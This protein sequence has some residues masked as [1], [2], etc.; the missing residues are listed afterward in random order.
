MNRVI[1]RLR[2]KSGLSYRI[3]PVDSV[4]ER[5][6]LTAFR[7]QA[8]W[9][10]DSECA[11]APPRVSFPISL[12]TDDGRTAVGVV[13]PQLRS[14]DHV[15]PIEGL[16]L[17]AIILPD[18]RRR[19]LGTALL[20]FAITH[21]F[22]TLPWL[23]T[24]VLPLPVSNREWSEAFLARLGVRRCDCVV[25]DGIAIDLFETDRAAWLDTGGSRWAGTVSPPM[26]AKVLATAAPVVY[27]GSTSSNKLAQYAYLFR[28][29][30]L[31]LRRLTH[32]VAL[33]EPQVEGHGDE[34]ETAL[35]AEPLK[36]FSRFAERAQI[37]PFVI[38]D[39]M[40]FIEHFNNDFDDQPM[41]PGPDTKRWWAALGTEGLLKVM[42]ESHLRRAT[43]VCQLGAILGP[44]RYEFFRAEVHGHISREARVS[45]E[46]ERS[47]PY[48]NAAYFH[49]IFIPQGS[50]RTLAEME[51]S[52]FR[53]FDYRRRCLQR[54]FTTLKANARIAHTVQP[55]LPLLK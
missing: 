45:A 18:Y 46:A 55:E 14:V 26:L 12:W 5:E 1:G 3:S 47:F 23:L 11:A 17:E 28:C 44:S 48:S 20:A 43:Y 36:D 37:Y 31:E 21:Y 29:F 38:E 10:S 8:V 7:Y 53:R 49:S 24:I 16:Y 35:V 27:F 54:A 34:H 4:M 39:T 25:R 15:F 42:D 52:E 9:R 50:T 2:D 41:L 33:I 30:G 40:L 6:F 13:L 32:S 19:G 51:P 22:A